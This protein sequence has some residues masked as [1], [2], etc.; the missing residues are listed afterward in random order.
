MLFVL[1]WERRVHQSCRE[2]ENVKDVSSVVKCVCGWNIV[3]EKGWD[4]SVLTKGIILSSQI[5]KSFFLSRIFVGFCLGFF[6]HMKPAESVSPQFYGC[7][8][9][10]HSLSLDTLICNVTDLKSLK[11]SFYWAFS[12]VDHWAQKV[13]RNS[14][15]SNPLPSCLPVKFSLSA[16]EGTGNITQFCI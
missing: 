2:K 12:S 4:S 11:E 7:V 8:S 9:Y 3:P 13:C 6:P 1:L 5:S 15:P 16:N 10:S 14:G